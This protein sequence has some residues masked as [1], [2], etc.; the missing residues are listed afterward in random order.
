MAWKR[1]SPTHFLMANWQHGRQHA[2]LCQVHGCVLHQA[3]AY[4]VSKFTK[5]NTYVCLY[6][7]QECYQTTFKLTIKQL[8]P[9][10]YPSNILELRHT[11][12]FLRT[13]K[14]YKESNPS[15]KQYI[16][17]FLV[18]TNHILFLIIYY[19]NIFFLCVCL[20]MCICVCVCVYVLQDLHENL[21]MSEMQ[22]Y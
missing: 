20:C 19:F 15:R 6:D 10:V 2:M 1:S 8:L 14:H 13:S 17:A 4:L 3:P 5:K 7:Y 18:L 16:R 21:H 12:T 22:H 9:P 11:T